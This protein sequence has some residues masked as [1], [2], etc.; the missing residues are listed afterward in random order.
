MP[1][2]AFHTFP[3]SEFSS[4]AFSSLA[5]SAPPLRARVR[6]DG[7]HFEHLLWTFYHTKMLWTN[8]GD[9][10]GGPA[11]VKPTLLVTLECAGRIQWFLAIWRTILNIKF[12]RF[13]RCVS[14]LLSHLP[15]PLN[16][17]YAFKCYQ[18]NVTSKNV[19]WLHFSW[20]TLYF[21]YFHK[22][23]LYGW[24]CDFQVSKVAQAK[25][26]TLNSWGGRFNHLSMAYLLSNI[27]TKNY[28]N[29]TTTVKIV[30]GGWVVYFWDSVYVI[31]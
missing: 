30:V 20:A 22:M 6:P 17:A 4:P 12:L 2:V 28:W 21:I 19:S 1:L 23:F 11:K 27:C 9:L 24:V 18:N 10:Q 13:L 26:R 31:T 16:F 29:W 25:V 15:K 14:K 3:V 8:K 7:K 5:F